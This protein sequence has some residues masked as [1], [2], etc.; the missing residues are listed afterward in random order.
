MPV[1]RNAILCLY[2]DVLTEDILLE[3][4]H[5]GRD[6]FYV[7]ASMIDILV[8]SDYETLKIAS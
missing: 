7:N 6:S 8:D 1:W 2:L 4:I 5:I 3:K